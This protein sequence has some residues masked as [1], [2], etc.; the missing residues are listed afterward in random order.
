MCEWPVKHFRVRFVLFISQTQRHGISL[1]S[2]TDTFAS[3]QDRR[4]TQT[5]TILFVRTEVVTKLEG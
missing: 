5:N 2:W 3:F 1:Y 4:F